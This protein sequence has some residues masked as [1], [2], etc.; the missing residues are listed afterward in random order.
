[1]NR[2]ALLA[3]AVVG[4]LGTAVAPRFAPTA[5]LPAALVFLVCALGT[6]AGL[7]TVSYALSIDD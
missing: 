5:G 4:L 3:A 7:W 1:M 6:L 2:F